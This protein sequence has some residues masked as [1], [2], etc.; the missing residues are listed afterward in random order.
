MCL[1]SSHNKSVVTFKGT[2]STLITKVTASTFK[3]AFLP[4][5]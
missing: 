4:K 5:L 2:T 3:P 1:K